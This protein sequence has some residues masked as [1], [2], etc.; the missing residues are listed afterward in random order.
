M[1]SSVS[2]GWCLQGNFG[3]RST[4]APSKRLLSLEAEKAGEVLHLSL[5]KHPP[6]SFSAPL[7]HPAPI[8]APLPWPL[9][10]SPFCSGTMAHFQRK[11]EKRRARCHRIACLLTESLKAAPHK[12]KKSI[13]GIVSP[14]ATCPTKI[15]LLSSLFSLPAFFFYLF[16][17]E[18]GQSQRWRFFIRGASSCGFGAF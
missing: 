16:G 8:P 11:E 17:R 10:C 3:T 1:E 2:T 9:P 4:Q 7:L 15:P 12:S 5:D 14:R 6:P 18:S 13:I